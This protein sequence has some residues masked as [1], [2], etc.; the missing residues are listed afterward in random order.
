MAKAK[1]DKIANSRLVN[2]RKAIPNSACMLLKV[3]VC[4]TLNMKNATRYNF[5]AQ[6]GIVF[7]LI[8]RSVEQWATVYRDSLRYTLHKKV[9]DIKYP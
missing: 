4:L 8:Y 9:K 1:T 2:T 5:F 3:E 6:C 7:W